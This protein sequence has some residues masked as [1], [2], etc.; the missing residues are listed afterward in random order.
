MNLKITLIAVLLTFTFVLSAHRGNAQQCNSKVAT[1]IRASI[2][3]SYQSMTEPILTFRRATPP[4]DVAAMIDELRDKGFTIRHLT[5]HTTDVS[6]VYS[7]EQGRRAWRLCVSMVGRYA[8]LFSLGRNGQKQLITD[9]PPAEPGHE[10]KQS[11]VAKRYTLLDKNTLN[12]PSP[13]RMPNTVT[14]GGQVR[15]WQALMRDENELPW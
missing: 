2:R 5:D 15:F 12:C 3:S 4:Q 8:T 1:D 13:L 9:I 6:F 11:V 7:L 10:I 14:S